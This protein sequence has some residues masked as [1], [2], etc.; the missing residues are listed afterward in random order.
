MLIGELSAKTNLSRD[1]I[2]FY[3]KEGLIK[4]GRKQ[5][6][7]NNY[8]E[9]DE[10][11][12]ERLNL[13]K[14]IKNFGFTLNETADLISLIAINA[15]TCDEVRN[16][17]NKKVM[18]IDNKIADLLHLRQQ[19]INNVQACHEC[20]QAVGHDENCPIIIQEIK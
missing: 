4:I 3:E 19:L 18:V 13:I 2:R 10:T 5:R 8:K 14:R 1:T 11:V 16:R 17:T 20:C 9:Y 15:A 7:E 12:I 6:R